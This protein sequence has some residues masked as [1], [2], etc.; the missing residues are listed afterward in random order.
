MA[1]SCTLCGNKED[2]Y[3]KGTL[4]LRRIGGVGNVC[5]D[6]SQ[7]SSDRELRDNKQYNDAMTQAIISPKKPK[8]KAL[9]KGGSV[10]SSG[11]CRGCNT[12]RSLSGNCIC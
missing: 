4:P 12:L 2:H 11:V 9:Q 1:K 8:E 7:N 6:C 3:G 5:S 10:K